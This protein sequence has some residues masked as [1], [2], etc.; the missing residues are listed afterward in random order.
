MAAPD[1]VIGGT[2]V[3]DLRVRPFHTPPP[4]E[5]KI[6]RHV[7]D[8]RLAAGGLTCNSG[9]ALARMGLDT[10]AL[11]RLGDDAIGTVLLTELAAAGLRVEGFHRR[12]GSTTTA[13]LVCVDEA[14]ERSFHV[15]PGVNP[16]FGPEDLEREWE[17]LCGA[18]AIVLGYLGGLP[19]LEP[20]LPVLLARLRRESTALLG[21]ETAGPQTHTRPLLDQCLPLLDVFFPS[22]EEAR[23][24][25]GCATPAEALADLARIP[26]PR[27]LGIK[28]GGDGC[29]LWQDH[30]ILTIPTAPLRVVDATGAGDIFL[31][32]LLAADLDGYPLPVA[33][34]VGHLAASLAIGEPGGAARIPPL[35]SLVARLAP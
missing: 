31:A 6:M 1:V 17:N 25:T 27:I 34:R 26:G 23:D 30:Q 11:G 32:G 4:G 2:T 3:A 19:L 7:D 12:P 20:R 5:P 15:G 24:L 21:L 22:W 13:V 10:L 35:A 29:L 8:V 33:C 16:L 14:G 9:M 18:R 28:T